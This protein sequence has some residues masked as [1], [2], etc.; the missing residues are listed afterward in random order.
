M[1]EMSLE[2]LFEL[3][4]EKIRGIESRT[5]KMREILTRNKERDLNGLR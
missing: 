5:E 1:Q 2:R 3:A 4:T